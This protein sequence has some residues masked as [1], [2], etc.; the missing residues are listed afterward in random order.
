MKVKKEEVEVGDIYLATGG[1]YIK[2]V[3]INDKRVAYVYFN[4]DKVMQSTTDHI[5]CFK[6]FTFIPQRGYQVLSINDIEVGD[7]FE[8]NGEEIVIDRIR[9]KEAVIT[10]LYSNVLACEVWPLS[11]LMSLTYARNINHVVGVLG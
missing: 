3:H 4:K 7:I 10:W 9:E 2:V 1:I 8:F 6:N 11:G 5:N